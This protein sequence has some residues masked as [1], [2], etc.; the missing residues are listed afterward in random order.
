MRFLNGFYVL[1]SM[2]L[3]MYGA[4]GDSRV[5][6]QSKRVS[7][8]DERNV[9][10][11]FS[12]GNSSDIGDA[13]SSSDDPLSMM[14]RFSAIELAIHNLDEQ[15]RRSKQDIS[16]IKGL[17]QFQLEPLNDQLDVMEAV[18][19]AWC[20]QL[21]PKAPFLKRFATKKGRSVR[22]DRAFFLRRIAAQD[23][24]IQDCRAQIRG[25]IAFFEPQRQ[26]HADRIAQLERHRAALFAQL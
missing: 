2:A 24:G 10:E 22:R 12:R 26:E 8:G 13:S 23:E 15:I 17:C 18:R 6:T 7:F 5:S 3:P 14:T 25:I 1:V 16:D 20:A 11:I 4:V 21:P 19:V 9:I